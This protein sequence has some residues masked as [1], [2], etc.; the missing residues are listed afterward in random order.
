MRPHRNRAPGAVADPP[1]LWNSPSLAERRVP[2]RPRSPDSSSISGIE[3]VTIDGYAPFQTGT[4][5]AYFGRSRADP[6]RRRG[7]RHRGARRRRLPRHEAGDA[8]VAGRR[9]TARTTSVRGPQAARRPLDVACRRHRRG[10]KPGCQ[11][12]PDLGRRTG[13]SLG[14]GGIRRRPGRL[15]ELHGAAPERPLPRGGGGA[16]GRVRRLDR[17][18]GTSVRAHRRSRVEAQVDLRDR[19][20]QRALRA[21]RGSDRRRTRR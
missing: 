10:G 8:R 21:R 17:T 1:P 15:R 12:S 2:I 6:R 18:A 5:P 9:G 19:D 14:P 7:A 20:E 11:A 13:G 16:A 4:E 3:H